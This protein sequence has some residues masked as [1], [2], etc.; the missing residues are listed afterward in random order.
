MSN[1]YIFQSDRL[2]DKN[3]WYVITADVIRLL[4]IVRKLILKLVARKG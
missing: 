4:L 1:I 2:R 3:A